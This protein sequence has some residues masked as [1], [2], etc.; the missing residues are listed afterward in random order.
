MPMFHCWQ[1]GRSSCRGDGMCGL[2]KAALQKSVLS[3][4]H[5]LLEGSNQLWSRQG[6]ILTEGVAKMPGSYAASVLAEGLIFNQ[7]C[8]HVCSS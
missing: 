7:Q 8:L 1:E 2:K 3:G 4:T 5:A 6:A